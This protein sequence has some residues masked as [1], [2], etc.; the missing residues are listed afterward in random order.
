MAN[1]TFRSHYK[2]IIALAVVALLVAILLI[3]GGQGESDE[4]TGD[5]TKAELNE[6]E[7]R[8]T[9]T[10]TC[11]PVPTAASEDCIK[12]IKGNDGKIY[13]LDTT[14]G[15]GGIAFINDGKRVTAVGTYSTVDTSS[16]ESGIFEYDG[17]LKVRRFA[18]E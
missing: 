18:L 15:G 3:T 10:I 7:I 11:L 1:T 8:V 6:G 5:I 4:G 13:A 12:A 16:E 17:V 14:E 2:I 9:G